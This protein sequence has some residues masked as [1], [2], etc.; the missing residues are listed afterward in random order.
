MEIQ[1]N[2]R[3]CEHATVKK[4]LAKFL[5]SSICGLDKGF[6]SMFWQTFWSCSS[7][8][9]NLKIKN[10]QFCWKEH[11]SVKCLRVGCVFIFL[12]KNWFNKLKLFHQQSK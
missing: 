7:P 10:Y 12:K 2:I 9:K 4:L 5:L 8:G 1:E 6:P 11:N 3:A